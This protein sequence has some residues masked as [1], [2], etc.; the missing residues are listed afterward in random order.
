MAALIWLILLLKPESRAA[1]Y[2][3]F[4]NKRGK[5]LLHAYLK[6]TLRMCLRK[7]RKGPG[8]TELW[9]FS[10]SLSLCLF[11]TNWPKKSQKKKMSRDDSGTHFSNELLR[12]HFYFSAVFWAHAKEPY[13]P[14]MC[15]S[16]SMIK[17]QTQLGSLKG[18]GY[19]KHDIILGILC[20]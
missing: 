12:A 1:D 10:H 14:Y 4:L 11:H 5:N 3:A 20:T 17:D 15:F 19:T 2:R 18:I 7:Q 16:Q 13:M 6:F 9:L 8:E